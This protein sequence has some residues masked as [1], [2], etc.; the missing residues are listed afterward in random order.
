MTAS[1]VDLWPDTEGVHDPLDPLFASFQPGT[2]PTPPMRLA[3]FVRAVWHIVEP[4]TRYAHGRHI[5]VICLHLERMTYGAK[6]AFLAH[7]LITPEEGDS[8]AEIEKLLV[9]I[10]P[11]YMKSLLI[12]VIWPA[13]VWTIDPGARFLFASYQQT[14]AIRDNVKTRRIVESQWYRDRYGSRVRITSDQNEKRRFDLEAGGFRLANSVEGGNTGEGGDYVVADDPHNAKE[15][16][17]ET[18]RLKVPEWWKDVMASRTGRFPTNRKLVVMQRLHEDD[19]SGRILAEMGDYVHIFLPEEYNPNLRPGRPGKPARSVP[20]P[21]GRIDWRTTPGE[22]LWPSRFG[23]EEVAQ[24][25]P[26]HVSSYAHGGQYQQVPSPSEGDLFKRS[27]WRFW[28]PP[29]EHLGPIVIPQQDGRPLVITP[30][31]LPFRGDEYN[32]SWDFTFK[33]KKELRRA[34]ESDERDYVSGWQ[35]LKVGPDA[36]V[37]DRIHEI[38]DFVQTVKA[39]KAMRR[40]W[41]ENRRVWYEDAANGPAIASVLRS[42]IPGLIGVSTEGDSLLALAHAVTWLHEG[43]NI[44]LPHPVMC[45]W[46][47]E[48]IDQFAAFPTGAHDDDVAACLV[49]LR[50]MFPR[51]PGPVSRERMAGRYPT[52]KSR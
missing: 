23:R 51:I 30:R 20:S 13:W 34:G 46:V 6:E 39:I 48:V 14:L 9:N 41:P 10:P 17:S 1:K 31:K 37:M 50:R 26:P 25:K 35:W 22:L 4:Q 12:G 19:L 33:G 45:P 15:I 52:I 8:W 40:R 24:H 42:Q 16:W 38:F 3:D 11:R 28:E 47:W 18:K 21:L 29:N 49:G 44:Y 5:E 2:G 27:N 32:Q 36:F 43:H 7:G